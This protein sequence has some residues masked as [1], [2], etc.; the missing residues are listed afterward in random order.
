MKKVVKTSLAAVL[1]ASAIVPA[2]TAEAAQT[3]NVQDFVVSKDGKN[4]TV[5]TTLFNE[6][7]VEGMIKGNDVTFIKSTNGKIYS[8]TNF[9][10]ALVEANGNV[11]AALVMLEKANLEVELTTVEGEFNTNG[12]LV[13]KDETPEEKVNETFF[14]NLAA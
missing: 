5:N 12:E 14:Y 10:E 7:I 6:A 11:E 9:D 1:V 2:A 4:L 13:A 3:Q 8:K